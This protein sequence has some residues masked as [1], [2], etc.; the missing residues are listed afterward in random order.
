MN[1][2]KKIFIKKIDLKKIQIL[3]VL[4]IIIVLFHQVGFILV[5]RGK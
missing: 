2:L 4:E 3:L 5:N 1:I